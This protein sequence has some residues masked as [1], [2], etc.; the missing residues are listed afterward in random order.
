M[1]FPEGNL[2]KFVS[3]ATRVEAGIDTLFS[4]QRETGEQLQQVEERM[5]KISVEVRDLGVW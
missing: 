4:A 1:G 3:W 5:G 2:K